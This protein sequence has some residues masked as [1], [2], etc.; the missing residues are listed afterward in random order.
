MYRHEVLARLAESK[1]VAIVREPTTERAREVLD[2]ALAG[3]VGAVEITFTTP[4]A[5]DLIREFS[6][7]AGDDGPL[8]G[9]GTVLDEVTARLAIL[10]GVRFLVSPNLR[11]E[12]LRCGHRYGVPVI[13][14][15]GTA[16]E[17]VTALEAGADCVKVFPSGVLGVDWFRALRSVLPQTAF[18]PTGSIGPDEVPAWLEA[19]AVAVGVGG[20]LTT[21]TPEEITARVRTLL[22]TLP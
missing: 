22:T 4:G 10:A 20:Q 11:G 21:G 2:A 6:E 17:V 9:A 16:D 14:G 12:V 13:P 18:V 15:A 1:V 3:G 5:V 8:V 19:G 7:R